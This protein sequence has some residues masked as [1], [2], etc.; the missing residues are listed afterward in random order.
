VK[1]RIIIAAA[2]M[3]VS[4]SVL[5]GQAAPSTNYVT[6]EEYE[7]LKTQ[8]DQ[9]Q[10]ELADQKKQPGAVSQAEVDKTLEDIDKDIKANRS[11]ID[12]LRPGE[13]NFMVT[14][15]AFVNFT[16]SQKKTSDT[17]RRNFFGV[18]VSPTFLWMP[19]PR[20]FVEAEPEIILR[21]TNAAEQE[22]E[23]MIELEQMHISYVLNDYVTIDAGQ[24][25]NPISPYAERWHQAWIEKLPN[26]AVAFQGHDHILGQEVLGAQLRGGFPI[27]FKDWKADYAVFIANSP[28]LITEGATQGALDFDSFANLGNNYMGGG[29]IGLIPIPGFEFGYGAAIARVNP[30][31]AGNIT[32]HAVDSFLNVVYVNYVLDSEPLRGTLDFKSQWGWQDTGET[33]YQG[34]STVPGTRSISRNGGFVR[35]AYRPT[36]MEAPIK[37]FEP[38]V[39]WDM[40]NQK[41]TPIGFDQNTYSIG[42]DYWLSDACVVKAAYQYVDINGSGT[43][44]QLFLLQW[45][46]GF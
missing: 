43:D 15:L 24:M 34:T 29:R 35:L 20:L 32:D 33:T 38:V 17:P 41:S 3:L 36:K 1:H 11:G 26:Q 2:A 16:S 12:A 9:V 42:L 14:G 45:A 7:K 19:T 30:D 44:N 28:S 18:Q 46:I 39:R 10:K 31:V 25:L 40:L 37:N 22:E 4:G 6:R 27:G 21:P 23:T 8:L 5:Y 13:S